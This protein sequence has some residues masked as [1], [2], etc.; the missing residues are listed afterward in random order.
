M[1]TWG[2]GQLH[3]GIL[4]L[5]ETQHLSLC[6]TW[7]LGALGGV[8]VHAEPKTVTRG[9]PEGYQTSNGAAS[10]SLPL[11]LLLTPPLPFLP[12]L[13]L[14]FSLSLLL[15][16][17]PLSLPSPLL[18][19]IFL[20]LPFFVERTKFPRWS[21]GK[22]MWRKGPFRPVQSDVVLG[23]AAEGARDHQTGCGHAARQPLGHRGRAL[24]AREGKEAVG[25]LKLTKGLSIG[26]VHRSPF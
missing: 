12:S 3:R 13:P 1:H 15:P 8:P 11:S 23:G 19:F 14:S 26:F 20:F 7:S 4:R 10:L 5:G 21:L 18:L 2:R 6:A 22:N 24:S 17:S 25:R 16:P 9:Q